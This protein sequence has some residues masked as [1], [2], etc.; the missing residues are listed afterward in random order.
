MARRIRTLQTANELAQGTRAGSRLR[1][2]VAGV[3]RRART[4]QGWQVPLAALPRARPDVVIVP[5]LAAK[6]PSALEPALRRRDVA[7][8]GAALCSWSRA[9][10]RV[11][12]ACTGTFVVANAGLLDGRRATTT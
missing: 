6:S 2:T 9:G 3:R 5:A 10:T 11:A 7:Q 8:V 1:V 12:A 4:Q